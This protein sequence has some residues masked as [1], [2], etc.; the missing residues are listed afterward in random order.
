[1]RCPRDCGSDDPK[2]VYLD[3][4]FALGD[5]SP[6]QQ[7]IADALVLQPGMRM[8]HI[9]VGC[10]DLARRAPGVTIDGI[11][12]LDDEVSVGSALGLPHYR[13]WKMNKYGR[14]FLGIPGPYDRIVDNNP[15]SFACC[16]RHFHRMTEALAR[17][18]APGGEVWTE[19]RGATWRQA[20]GLSIDW[21]AWAR[22]GVRLGLL[23]ERRGT[24]WVW[25]RSV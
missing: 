18:L 25:R 4:S 13:V 1:M 8:L 15:G 3:R 6:D 20:G 10:S 23:A 21:D 2:A 19:E 22:E 11:T 17:L 24:I 5:I 14:A 9:G 16:H 12:V 7:R